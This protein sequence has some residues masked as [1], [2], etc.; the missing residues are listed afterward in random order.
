MGRLCS[1][2]V[3]KSRIF[4]ECF[5]DW[6]CFFELAPAIT[7]RLANT[8]HLTPALEV[9]FESQLTDAWI[10]R[11]QDSSETARRDRTDRTVEIRAVEEIEEFRAEIRR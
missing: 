6:K 5:L 1:Q 8:W 4:W 11:A 3:G 9:Q 10:S 7:R 2:Y